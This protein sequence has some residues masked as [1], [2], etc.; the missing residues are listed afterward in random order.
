MATS[1]VKCKYC[2]VLFNKEKEEHIKIGN[3]YAH[4]ACH[5]EH[6]TYANEL[7]KLTDYIQSLYGKQKTNWNIVGTQIKK[8]KGEGMTYQGMLYTLVYFYEIK[9]NDINKSAGIGIIPYQYHKAQQYYEN[10]DNVYTQKAKIDAQ[11]KLEVD[12]TENIITIT[13]KKREKKLIDF[14]Y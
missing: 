4:S 8:Y 11:D 12:Q 14:D 1:Y 3:R 10:I 13:Q 9:K 6:L 7:K 2:S 5:T